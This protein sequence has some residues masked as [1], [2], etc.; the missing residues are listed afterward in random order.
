[1]SKK[2]TVEALDVE[3]ANAL[4]PAN[5]GTSAELVQ[6]TKLTRKLAKNL[7][8]C[9]AVLEVTNHANKMTAEASREH[10]E[11]KLAEVRKQFNAKQ[12]ELGPIDSDLKAWLRKHTLDAGKSMPAKYM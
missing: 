4:V 6:S 2:N 10:F 7:Q 3:I 12:A 11:A 5:V 9:Q 8:E 1:M